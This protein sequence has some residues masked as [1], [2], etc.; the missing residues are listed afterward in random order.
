LAAIAYETGGMAARK[1]NEAAWRREGG[2][3]QAAKK[4][5]IKHR[6][7]GGGSVGVAAI[8]KA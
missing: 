5:G 6:G 3:H 4:R 7:D 8:I 2:G 1:R